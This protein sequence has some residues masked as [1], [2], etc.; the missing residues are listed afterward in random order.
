VTEKRRLAVVRM[1][2]VADLCEGLSV[3]QIAKGLAAR[4][5]PSPTGRP[6]SAQAVQDLLK[7]EEADY[8]T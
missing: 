8:V 3:V 6:W 5:V 2:I 4:G 7:R 1:G